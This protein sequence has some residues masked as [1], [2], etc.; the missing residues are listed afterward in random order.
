MDYEKNM[1]NILVSKSQKVWKKSTKFD[2]APLNQTM[3]ILQE[4]MHTQCESSIYRSLMIYSAKKSTIYII[5]FKQRLGLL[6]AINIVLAL[7]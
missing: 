1:G 6:Y 4:V 3:N 7:E 2:P 5:Y